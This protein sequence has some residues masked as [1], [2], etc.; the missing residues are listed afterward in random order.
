MKKKLFAAVT[1]L[2][3]YSFLILGFTFAD[4]QGYTS[5]V[6]TELGLTDQLSQQESR[7]DYKE[8]CIDPTPEPEKPPPPPPVI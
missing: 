7:D 4:N 8:P 1:F 5:N 2:S 3:L 6:L